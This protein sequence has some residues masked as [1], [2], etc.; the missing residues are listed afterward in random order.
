MREILCRFFFDELYGVGFHADE[1]HDQEQWLIIQVLL[2]RQ[3][4]EDLF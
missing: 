4:R 1:A 3:F 2:W